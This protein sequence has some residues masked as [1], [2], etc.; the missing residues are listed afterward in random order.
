MT[1]GTGPRLVRETPRNGANRRE[2]ESVTTAVLARLQPDLWL[3]GV[4][5]VS[6]IAP[7]SHRS[8]P[9]WTDERVPHWNQQSAGGASDSRS[10]HGLSLV[11][12]DGLEPPTSSL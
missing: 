3:P 10:R 9:I 1:A 12:V 7:V 6:V 5:P 11:G 8:T 2:V 4:R